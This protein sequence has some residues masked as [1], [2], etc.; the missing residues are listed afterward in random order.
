MY[1][2]PTSCSDAEAEA[3]AAGGGQIWPEAEAEA[4]KLHSL[5][6]QIHIFYKMTYSAFS[7]IL[8]ITQM[9][10]ITNK[11]N[12]IDIQPDLMVIA[13]YNNI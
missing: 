2:T 13:K 5:R 12:L 4:E 3:K 7:H 1:Y 11:C 10:L 9:N 8:L 6:L